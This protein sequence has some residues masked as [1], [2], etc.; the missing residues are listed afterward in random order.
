MQDVSIVKIDKSNYHLFL[1][2]VYWRIKGIEK[3]DHDWDDKTLKNGYNTL[4]KDHIFVYGVLQDDKFVGWISLVVMPKIGPKKGN[5]FV[6]ELWVAP[7]YRKQ[8]L[9][10]LLI[11]KGDDLLAS[12][13]L[14]GY[15]LYVGQDNP[16][17]QALYKKE[18]FKIL[19]QTFFMEKAKNHA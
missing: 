7:T 14:D 9:G 1:N 12:L 6:D 10:S 11:K 16:S 4:E 17:A 13:D 15:R 2:M 5:L 19:D 8:G 3:T 18:G